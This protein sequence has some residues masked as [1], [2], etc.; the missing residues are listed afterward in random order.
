MNLA[1][2]QIAG[3]APTLK[4]GHGVGTELATDDQGRLRTSGEP[5]R[6]AELINLAGADTAFTAPV[7]PRWVRATG[8]GV[9]KVDA[10]DRTGVTI[11]A[12]VLL[13]IAAGETQMLGFATKIYNTANGTTATGLTVYF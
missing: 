9:I 12:G 10:Y 1:Q 7:L 6:G 13:P 11:V 2:G 8:A 3:T 5:P 4:P